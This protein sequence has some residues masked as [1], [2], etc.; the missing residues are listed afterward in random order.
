MNR[1]LVRGSLITTVLF[2][3]SAAFAG[4]NDPF[5]PCFLALNCFWN[6]TTWICAN[7]E[8]YA[9]CGSP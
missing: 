3:A 4:P 2:F 9:L 6:G 5:D 8:I 7:P 1:K